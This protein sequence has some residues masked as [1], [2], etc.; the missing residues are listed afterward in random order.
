[1][2][3]ETGSREGDLPG[4]RLRKDIFM[5]LHHEVTPGHKLSH[6]TEMARGLEAGKEG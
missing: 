5:D 1:M 6:K 4:L 2:L 3:E